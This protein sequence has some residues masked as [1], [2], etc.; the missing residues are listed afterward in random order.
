MQWAEFIIALAAF[1]AAHALPLRLKAPLVARLGRRG[2]ALGYSLLSLGLLY[3]L[4]VAAGRAPWVPLW[5]QAV[6]MRWLV[7]LAMPVAIL[8]ALTGGMAGLMAAFALWA[9]A[10]LL[11]NGDLAHVLF[12]GLMLTYACLGVTLGL[13]RGLVLR[14]GWPRLLAAPLIW[15]ALF[16]LHPLVI[17]VSPAP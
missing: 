7:N 6:W 8:L 12:F 2:F 15:A 13:R 16:H 3:W 9:G 4:I 1:L 10:H 14:L 17:G 5:P 11:A